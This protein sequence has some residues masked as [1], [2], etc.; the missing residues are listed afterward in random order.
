[1]MTIRPL[2]AAAVLAAGLPL[3]ALTAPA[4]AQETPAIPRNDGMYALFPASPEAEKIATELY[5][6]YGIDVP[7]EAL[8]QGAFRDA[9]VVAA[10]PPRERVASARA[11]VGVA[12]GAT[13]IGLLAALTALIVAVALAVM[14]T[15]GAAPAR[16]AVPNEF[17]G[18]VAEDVYIGSDQYQAEQFKKIHDLGFRVVR[19]SF[20]WNELEPARG[21]YDF[22]ATD[23]YVLA[24]AKAGVRVQ[25]VLFGEPAWASSRPTGNTLRATFPPTNPADFGA[26]AAAVARRYGPGGSLWAENRKGVVAYPFGTYQLWNEPNLPI[27]WGMK[28]NARSY[29]ALVKATATAIKQ[30]HPKGKIVTGGIPDSR[31]GIRAK[32]YLRAFLKAGG[33]AQI[34]A[35]AIHP[36]ARTLK[37]VLEL[38]HQAR[39]TLD[40]V[41][42]KKTGLVITEIGWA[43]GGPR[44]PARTVKAKEQAALVPAMYK[45]FAKERVAL[46]LRAVMYFAWRDSPTYPGRS[47]FWGLRTGLFTINGTAKPVVAPLTKT[48]NTLS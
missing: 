27:Y 11:G 23:R 42:G 36:Y 17:K 29:A 7:V 14:A 28:P 12:A 44:T 39:E 38:T 45:A 48:L 43:V 15:V 31:L 24:A 5:A 4:A 32:P 41:G 1:M 47:D 34:G 37:E 22:S 35:V 25:P 10:A 13:K 30:V 3:T 33:G 2:A 46:N 19:Q 21:I 8:R 26:F 6:T 40:S 20:R 9:K 16:A 18:V